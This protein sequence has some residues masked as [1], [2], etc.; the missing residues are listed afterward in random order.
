MDRTSRTRTSNALPPAERSTA[1]ANSISQKNLQWILTLIIAFVSFLVFLP[2]LS[3]Q[4]VNW[5]DYETLVDN[6]HY[7]GLSWSHVRWM[8][9]TFHM[10][11]YQPLSWLTLGLDYLLWGTNPFGYHLTNLFLHSANAVFFFF[12]AR[13][14]LKR[15]FKLANDKSNIRLDLAAGLAALLFSIHP[16]RVESVVW[17]TERRD[18]LSGLFFLL[19]LYCY[20]RSHTDANEKSRRS[21]VAFSL[22]AFMLSLSA[23]ASAITLPLVL[24]LLDVYPLRRVAGT[25]RSW[26]TPEAKKILWEKLPFAVPAIIFAIIAIFAQQSATA[27]RPVQQYFISY[28]VEQAFYGIVFYLWKSII[29]LNLSPLYELPYDFD[30]WTGLFLFCAAA[31]LAISAALYLLRRRWPAVLAAWVCYLVVLAPVAGIAQSGPQLVADRYSY[32]SCMSWAVLLAGAFFYLLNSLDARHGGQSVLIAAL[33][34]PG[35]VMMIFAFLTWKQTEVWRDTRSLWNHVIAVAPQSSVAYYN[36]ARIVENEGKLAKGVELYRQALSNNPL[37]ADAHYNLARLLTKQGEQNEAIAHY[38][39]TLKIRPNDA[40][41]HN[42]LGLLLAA[43]GEPA[44]A[45]EEFHRALQID[46]KYAKAFFNMGRVLAQQNE[47]D[48]AVENYRQALTVSPNEIE[49]LVVLAEALARRGQFAEA[50]MHL[51]KAIALKPEIPDVHVA[52]ARSLAAQG[53][54]DEAEK[55]YQEALRLLKAKNP[56]PPSGGPSQ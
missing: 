14:L 56:A 21:W 5:D 6:P 54:R 32:F 12:L 43:R 23:K 35:L 22:T 39:E 16:L 47:L 45:L 34:V 33:P 17:A 27:L 26:F 51:Q 15:A 1:Q 46:P 7:R 3:N 9:T 50:A 53:K 20:V 25:W 11:H 41:A 18:V 19:T 8:F 42:N 40:E 13:L 28:R 2:A 4:F 30:V 52:L 29:P 10:G 31:V 38:R 36:L 49:V 24:L 48:K 44:A 55:H 37:N